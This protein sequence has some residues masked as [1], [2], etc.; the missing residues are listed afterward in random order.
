MRHVGLATCLGL[1]A[2]STP[3]LY[4]LVQ[5][6]ISLGDMDDTLKYG[7]LLHGTIL[8]SSYED[9]KHLLDV[10]FYL[11]LPTWALRKRLNKDMKF[12]N[13]PVAFTGLGWNIAVLNLGGPAALLAGLKRVLE[14]RR[15]HGLPPPR[16]EEN[17][18]WN[19]HK[20]GVFPELVVVYERL[21]KEKNRGLALALFSMVKQISRPGCLLNRSNVDPALAEAILAF[22]VLPRELLRLNDGVE[23]GPPTLK[24]KPVIR[25]DANIPPYAIP[26]KQRHIDNGT[27]TDVTSSI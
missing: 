5:I 10:D 11:S 19:P 2:D 27:L 6:S 22:D 20:L 15:S 12:S 8:A 21:K 4:A 7:S 24:F 14:Y 3:A 25:V 13:T 1:P 16:S 23:K 18:S 17:F 26:G 9:R